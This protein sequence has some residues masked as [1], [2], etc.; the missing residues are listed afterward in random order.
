MNDRTYLQLNWK[1]RATL[2][3]QKDKLAALMSRER[4]AACSEAVTAK[5]IDIP[6]R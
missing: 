6:D 4:S 1:C 2:M 3:A 5:G